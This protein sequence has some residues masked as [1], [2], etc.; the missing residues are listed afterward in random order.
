MDGDDD[1]LSLCVVVAETKQLKERLSRLE[2]VDDDDDIND[3]IQQSEIT[4]MKGL[5][6]DIID[7]VA[8][9]SPSE[10]RSESAISNNPIYQSSRRAK[11]NQIGDIPG[12]RVPSWPHPA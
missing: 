11:T 2:K 1:E 3:H 10:S 4:P 5:D 7:A 8:I 12:I 9:D 6:L